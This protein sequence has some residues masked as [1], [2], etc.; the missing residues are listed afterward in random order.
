MKLYRKKQHG[1]K[2]R[3]AV[4]LV[5]TLVVLVVLTT[6]LCALAARLATLKHRRQ[7]MIDYQV[8]RYACDSG[9]KYAIAMVQGMELDFLDRKGLA[10]FSDIF[11]LIAF[12]KL[13]AKATAGQLMFDYT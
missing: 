2:D 11:N 1:I 7:Y 8:S 6:I 10:D 13:V 12:A 9:V 4:T 5:L 3:P